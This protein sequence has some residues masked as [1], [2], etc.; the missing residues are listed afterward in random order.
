MFPL[1]PVFPARPQIII[2]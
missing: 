1:F 2:Y